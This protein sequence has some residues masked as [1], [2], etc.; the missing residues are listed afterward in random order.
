[1]FSRIFIPKKHRERFDEVVSQSLMSRIKGRSFSD[2]SRSRLRRSR[3]RSE[4]HPEHLLVST[5]A[6]SVPRTHAEEGAIP[7]ARGMRKTTS[8][9]AGHSGGAA[10]NCRTV[11]VCKGNMSF[12]FTLRGH[13]PVW[14]DS[15]IPGSAADKAGLK[16]GDR[17]LFLN[18]LDMRTSSH[19]KVVSMLQGSGAM[20][21]LVVEDGTASFSLSEQDLVGSG[22]ATERARSPVLSSLQWVADILPSSIRVHGRTFGQQLE[23]LL[24]V[25]EKYT[26]CKALENFFQHRNVDTLIVD[27]FPVLD[28][29]AKQVIWQ[30]VY[31]L[32]TYEEQEHC[33]GKISRFL[34]FKATVPPPPPPPP[35]PEPEV[36]PHR[37]SSS[38][39]V[40]GTTYR[41]SVRGRSSDDLVIGT[42]LGMGYR[43][44]SLMEAGMRLAPGERQSGDG[45]SLPETPNNLTNLSAVYAE[46][47][48]MYSAKRSKSLKT[49]PPPAPET[50]L[51]LDPPSRPASPTMRAHTGSRKGP[52]PP[53]TWPEPPSSPPPS[54]FYPSGLTSQNSV[55]SNPY[56]SLDSPPSSPP[57]TADFLS[58][59]P[60][61]RSSKRRYTFSKPPRSEDTDRFLDAL[62]EQLGQRV[63]IVDD[64]LTPENDY[65]ED[66]VQ[67]AFP[68]DEE[69]E[70]EEELCMDEEEDDNGGFVGPE[71]SSPSDVQSSCGEENAS[72]LTYSSS[73]DHI[74]PPPM[75]P[76]PPPPVQFNDTPAPP[77]GAS[78]QSQ[79]QQPSY[80]PEQSPRT[81]VPV[82]RKSG[83]PP[84]PPPRNNQLPKRQ[85]LHKVLPTQDEMQVHAA[86]QELKAYQEQQERHNY[87]EQQAYKERQA[88]EEQKTFE[89]QQA[90]QEK[91]FKERQDYEEQKAYEELKAYEEQ[92]FQEQ[93]AYQERQ[94][95]EQR[96]AFQEQKA[97]E[98]QLMQQ[99]YQSHHSMP[100]QPTQQKAHSP[101]LLQQLHQSLPPIPAPESTNNHARHPLYMMRQAQ[102]QQ[103]HQHH[104]HHRRQSRSAPPP[105]QPPPQPPAN[106]SSQYS[107]GVYQSHQSFRAQPHHSSAEM[108]HQLQQAHHNQSA[109]MLQQMQ[110][111]SVHYSSAEILHQ[112]HQSKL[113]HS[114]KEALHQSHQMMQMQPHHSSTELLHQA[115]QMHRG[116]PH[117]SSTELLHQIHKPHHSSAELLH[118]PHQMHQAKPHHSSTE[119]L[120][121]DQQ[122]PSS[123]PVQLNRE[124]H[125]QSRRSLKGHHQTQVSPQGPTIH[126][127]PQPIKPCP[128]RPHSMQQT[129]HHS[130]APQIH[131]IHHMTPQ[132]PP[133]DFKH[134]IQVIHPPQQQPQRSHPL[135]STF[136][137]LQPHQPTLS[138][139]QPV[140]QHQTQATTQT[141]RPHSQPSHHLMQSQQPQVQSHHK[142]PQGQ[143]QPVPH[144]L[145]DPAEPLEPPPPP[146]LP[147]PCSPPPLPRPALS[148]MD[149][150]HMS[151]KRLRWEQVENSEGTIWG[152]LGANSEH[153]KLHDMVKYLD[154]EMHFGTQ[155]GSLPTPE[156]LPQLEAFKKKDV[157]EILSHKKAY[158]A[159]IL[160]AHLKLSPG[161]LRQVLMNMTSDRLE[162]PHIKQ[163]LLYAP[164]AEEVKKYKEYSDHPGKLSE[165]DQFVLQMLSV[166][167]YKTRL[168]SLHFKCSLQEKTDELRG[169][170][171]C[172]CKASSELKSS[173]KL[174]K[175]LEFVLAMG[176]YLNNSQPKTSKT[177]GFKINFLT[178]L[179]TTKTVDGKSTF[180]HIL[181]KSLCHH[182]P[183]VLD[184]SKDLTKVPLAAKVNQRTI[185]SDVNDLH[186]TIQ[187][188]RSACQKMPTTA[189]D[190]FA[191]VMSNFLE[192][193]HPA[194]QSLESLQQRAVEEFSKTASFFG[195]DSKSTNTEAF[196]G[197]FAEFI[198]KFEKALSDQQVAE[199]PKSPRSPRMASPLAW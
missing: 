13:A 139:F 12:G 146:P 193:S 14:I 195:E 133:Q 63:A 110:Q 199:N 151:V 145:S 40:T 29:P 142:P 20:P 42:H 81:Y 159:S 114:S 17:I 24:T 152:Q 25:Q 149:S 46:L 141:A 53:T 34:G 187:T 143:N 89:E 71:L 181:V 99:I 131:H 162:P 62:S 163:L 153:E 126:H 92:M 175:I 140:P 96:Q 112:I 3:S 178:E 30:F 155:K 57:E 158:N 75:T 105:H 171:E 150:H 2:P 169:A 106:P 115:H 188:I 16:P 189:E 130:S 32:L 122:E 10:T 198:N 19:E 64:F 107:E 58:S 35:P 160:I 95:F 49:R 39:R 174:A 68:D 33:Q 41:S 48:N 97:Y 27:V 120:H 85:S 172:I 148:R 161:E 94:A 38:V 103:G 9:I 128:Q 51:D 119:M 109:E 73:S 23:H 183:D 135:L 26:I 190:R 127:H 182:F 179:S 78:A 144:S 177:T 125:L 72:S 65:E 88:Y 56:I 6:S 185:T 192:N 100:S 164:D 168:E 47:E 37:R 124:S 156:P 1:M 186:A 15:V 4:D 8:L 194:V 108:L 66:V 176:N 11:R 134:Q 84:P 50:L 91:M 191:V 86:I 138:T 77:P 61:R 83:P 147:P 166:P 118:Q 52:P 101:L 98:E 80:T 111:P 74:P 67:M 36:E 59:P 69:E 21:T 197:I 82:R 157:V 117:R 90:Y 184:F 22:L 113:H 173:K 180:L 5:R 116:Q 132:P 43:A 102:Q 70:N 45:T 31:Q 137:P 154:L 104:Q 7:P 55:D 136:Q 196:F 18:G 165:P 170:Y 60:P 167:E 93:Q 76:P 44:D 129:H 54:Q 79:Q 28:T 123:L 87:E 121:Q